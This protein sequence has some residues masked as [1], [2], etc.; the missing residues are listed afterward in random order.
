MA[1]TQ[2]DNKNGKYHLYLLLAIAGIWVSWLV[3]KLLYYALSYL[4]LN[5]FLALDLSRYGQFSPNGWVGYAVLGLGLGAACGAVSAQRRFRLTK[6]IPAG[7]VVVA[8]GLCSFVFLNNAA[9]FAPPVAEVAYYVSSDGRGQCPA[10][11]TIEATSTKP[12]VEPD[13][14]AV[15][16]LLDKDPA[17]A[18][19]SEES[20]NQNLRLT[21]NIPADQQLVG[22]RL[23][24]GYGKSDE[25]FTSFSRIRTCRVS[26]DNG[27]ETNWSLPDTHAQDLFIPIT[28]VA[29]TTPQVLLLRVDQT[30]S[31]ENH[32]EVALS[33]LTPIIEP[34]SK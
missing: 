14:Y 2:K 11:T 26:L 5:L 28:P 16:K 20:S 19:I 17:T 21:L 34:V 15:A 31:G 18:W 4:G 27:P 24:N 6:L 12:S 29:G 1:V 10:C 13:R 32:A 22:L 33:A 9:R 7:A 30:Y 8:L 25:V 3:L 23:G